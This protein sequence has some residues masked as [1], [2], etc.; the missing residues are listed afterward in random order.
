MQHAEYRIRI[1]IGLWNSSV[2]NAPVVIASYVICMHSLDYSSLVS[3][4]LIA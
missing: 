4:Q 3:Y 2:L 1:A